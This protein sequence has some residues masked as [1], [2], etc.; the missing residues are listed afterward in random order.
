MA[1]A[2]KQAKVWED[3]E[4]EALMKFGGKMVQI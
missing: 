3:F 1:Y 4:M 2:Y